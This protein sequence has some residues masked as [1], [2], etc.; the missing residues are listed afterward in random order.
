MSAPLP[1]SIVVPVYN[2]ETNLQL[3]HDRVH[4]AV[5]QITTAYEVIWVND[6][7]QDSSLSII[8]LLKASDHRNKY[9]TFSRN[10][11][12][13]VAVMAGI[14]YA[15]GEVV[16]TIDG[17][18]QDP[19][20]L[21]PTLWEKHKEGYRVVYAQRR[22]RAGEKRLRN[23]SIKIFYR[24]LHRMTKINIPV[25][26]GDFRLMDRTVINA[27][28]KMPEQHKFLRG[29]IAWVGFKQAPVFYDR[30][31]RHGGK[32]N[33]GVGKLFRLALDGFTAFSNY[34]LRVA[35]ISGFVVSFI[36]FLIILYAL[37]SKFVQKDLIS[38]WT[39]LIISTMFIGG[40]Q[41]ICIGLIGEYIGRINSDVR[42]RPL[43]I[44]EETETDLE[45][46]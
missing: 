19:P 10:F 21:I 42:N 12:H 44:V 9:I 6:G 7:S 18:L 14:D 16:I 32:S 33:Y 15:K 45:E 36:A 20:E 3:M 46:K 37:Y 17:D 4:K 28:Q 13:Q 34:P 24:L 30:D 23:L 41:L 29:Q 26:T 2:E 22:K 31:A 25:D 27:L 5:A 43:Y 35:T 1:L 11:G 40:V 39:S 8:R 38:G